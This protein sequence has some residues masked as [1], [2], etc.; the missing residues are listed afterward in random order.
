VEGRRRGRA[1]AP[2][3]SRG[4]TLAPSLFGAR[5]CALG[6]SHGGQLGRVHGGEGKLER[7]RGGEDQLRRIH[8]GQLRRIRARE[9][10]SD[11]FVVGK[12]S[13]CGSM[14]ASSGRSMVA[15]ELAFSCS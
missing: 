8:G 2:A 12:T 11:R 5:G 1:P 7:I 10:S 4:R 15:Q 3:D 14:A 6:G 9:T 13:S